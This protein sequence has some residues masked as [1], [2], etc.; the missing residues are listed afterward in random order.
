MRSKFLV[1]RGYDYKN[2]ADVAEVISKKD[3]KE[4][5]KDREQKKTLRKY[6]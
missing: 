1:K 3:R 5:L 6:L 4:L 2:L